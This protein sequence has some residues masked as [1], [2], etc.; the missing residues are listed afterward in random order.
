MTGVERRG[1]RRP[2]ALYAAGLGFVL[3]AA[4]TEDGG[5]KGQSG[6][7]LEKTD[8]IQKPFK[9]TEKD[10][11]APE[12]FS[13]EESGLWDGR[14]SLGGIWIAHPDVK[15]PERV[16]I[17]NAS[18]GRE[19]TGALFRRER[20]I[21][22]PRLQAS[23]DAAEA[24]G[25]LPGAPVR[26]NVVALRREQIEEILPTPEEP[27]GVAVTRLQDGPDISTAAVAEAAPA[28]K[29][30]QEDAIAAAAAAAIDSAP[31]E[32]AAP[33]KAVKKPVR[34]PWSK[35]KADPV[36]EAEDTKAPVETASLEQ[37][38]AIAAAEPAPEPEPE[39][40]AKKKVTWPWSKPA[41]DK[42]APEDAVEA[43]AAPE[44]VETTTLGAVQIEPEPTPP[45][46]AEASDTPKKD[47]KPVRWPWAK[48]DAKVDPVPEGTPDEVAGQI[49]EGR[50]TTGTAAPAPAPQAR[51]KSSL[52]KP[53]V[54]VGTFGVEENARRTADLMRAT[55]IVPQ[56]DSV[57]SDG[58][59]RW[60]VIVGPARN[61]Q[62]RTA[63]LKQVK[64]SGFSDAYIVTN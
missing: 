39:K 1:G 52:S 13:A 15:D 19:V 64:E 23:S 12:V 61:R 54:Q 36:T 60:R 63:L 3:L 16:L 17:R 56:V 10:V 50:F 47:R 42:A 32:A 5:L 24:L 51:P 34:W 27:Q 55:G 37:P 14:P 6:A 9:V 46:R 7:R 40:K 28:K 11:Q 22:G 18:N 53:Y 30:P 49:T 45:P 4:C 38:E 57:S 41:R 26:L 43:P 48:R 58:K 31:E 29:K 25:M 62:E 21:P 8:G 44:A 59:S 20:D 35:R 33:E 2:A